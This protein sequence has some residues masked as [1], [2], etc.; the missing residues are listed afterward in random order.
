M[1]ADIM[2]KHNLSDLHLLQTESQNPRTKNIDTL[3]TPEVCKLINEEDATVTGAVQKCLPEIA[4][5]IDAVAPRIRGGGRLIYVGTGT[6]G[7]YVSC[8]FT[9]PQSIL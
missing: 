6:S 7:R 5:A 2:T 3:P 9:A 4:A 1:L 8:P